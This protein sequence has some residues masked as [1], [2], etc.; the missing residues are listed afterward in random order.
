[1]KKRTMTLVV[2]LAAMAQATTVAQ[3]SFKELSTQA[4][5]VAVGKI[6][7]ITAFQDPMGRV[8]SRVEIT[9]LRSVDGEAPRGPINFEMFGGTIGDLRQSVAGFPVLKEGDRVALF[10]AADT[11]SLGG[12]TVGAFQGVFFIDADN[13][14]RNYQRQPLT[15]LRGDQVIVGETGGARRRVTLDEFVSRISALRGTASGPARR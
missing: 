15:E 11:T 10:L 9:P 1:M 12:P 6:E 2:L 8:F 14:V 4:R 13:T 5:R 3:M 7:K